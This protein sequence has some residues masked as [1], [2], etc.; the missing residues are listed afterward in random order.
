MPNGFFF[1]LVIVHVHKD[2]S[3]IT[4]IWWGGEIWLEVISMNINIASSPYPKN[5]TAL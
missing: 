5:S 2:V 1:A 4:S 3:Q